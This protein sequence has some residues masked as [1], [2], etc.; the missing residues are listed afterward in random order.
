M[1]KVCPKCVKKD[2][3][4]IRYALGRCDVCG[5][6][7]GVAEVEYLPQ[8]VEDLFGHLGKKPKTND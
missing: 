3:R 5:T 4:P 1:K 6:Y 8:V 2:E 7:M